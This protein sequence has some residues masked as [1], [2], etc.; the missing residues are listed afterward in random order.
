MIR[1]RRGLVIAITLEAIA[2]AAWT[3][4]DEP[5]RPSQ[6][7]QVLGTE[8]RDGER[9]TIRD[10]SGRM[11]GSATTQGGRTTFRDSG[12]R[13]VGTAAQN[14]N[15]TTFRDS[16][17][18]TTGSAVNQG[19]RTTCRDS[20]GRTTASAAPAAAEEAV[21]CSATNFWSASLSLARGSFRSVP[22]GRSTSTVSPLSL[23]NSPSIV[24]PEAAS[25]QV[26]DEADDAPKRAVKIMRYT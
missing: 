14:G 7:M 22:L 15:R 11:T 2:A 9:A 25:V 6:S 8:A 24:R 16:S 1:I 4:A 23:R 10:P 21:P 26:R 5:R 20:S 13:V 12:G 17:G 3:S 19:N 18:R